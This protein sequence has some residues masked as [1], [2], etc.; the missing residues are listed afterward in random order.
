MTPR[1]RIVSLL[2]GATEIVC[3][4]GLRE[5]LVGVSH[6]CDFPP[7]VRGLPVVTAPEIDP[8]CT[9]REIDRALRERLAAGLSIYRVDEPLLASLAPDL[10][11]TQD[12]C[13]VCAVSPRQVLEAIR[14]IAGGA[15]EILSLRPSRLADVWDDVERVAGAAGVAGR[16]H[17]LAEA[18]RARV[19]ALAAA[20]ARVGSR[21]RLACIEWLD[22]LMVAGNWVPELAAAAGAESLLA[23]AGAHSPWLEWSALEASAPEV[24]CAMPCGFGLAQTRREIADLVAEPRWQSLPAIRRG[25]VYAVDGNAY[26][27]RPGPRLVE[28]AEILAGLVHPDAF[29]HLVPTGA[30]EVVACGPRGALSPAGG[31]D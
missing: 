10:I 21:P 16:G 22:P 24:L 27:N 13:E 30:A 26:F 29:G 23:T 8:G 5:N 20:T 6:E 1:P 12:Q 31:A 4:L 9:S 17:D 28:S 18:L 11:V 3:A 2:P 19:A 15:T 7:D 25:R 14:R